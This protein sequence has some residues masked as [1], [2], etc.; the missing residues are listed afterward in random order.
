MKHLLNYIIEKS[1]SIQE[2]LSL[3][4]LAPQNLFKRFPQEE[5][6]TDEAYKLRLATYLATKKEDVEKINQQLKAKWIDLPYK[7]IIYN[8]GTKNRNWW[9]TRKNMNNWLDRAEHDGYTCKEVGS[10]EDTDKKW[11]ITVRP[12]IQ[13]RYKGIIMDLAP[14]DICFADGFS[15]K[16][17]E[18]ITDNFTK[19]PEVERYIYVEPFWGDTKY[20]SRQINKVL[21]SYSKYFKSGKLAVTLSEAPEGMDKDWLYMRITDTQFIKDVEEEIKRMTDLDRLK[22]K[23]IKIDKEAAEAVARAKKEREERAAAAAKAE[24]ARKKREEEERAEMNRDLD[25]MRKK[26]ATEEE[27][28]KAKEEWNIGRWLDQYGKYD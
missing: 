14:D 5:A 21:D 18:K 3:S 7:T 24:V 12:T 2:N 28:E 15:M 25:D 13:K 10:W 27:I 4:D 22:A 19:A 26:G 23:K 20:E 8:K 9:I 6:E 1:D 11:E 17:I 16:N